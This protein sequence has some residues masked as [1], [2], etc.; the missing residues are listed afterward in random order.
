MTNPLHKKIHQHG[1]LTLLDTMGNDQAIV[2]AASVS[3]GGKKEWTPKSTERLIRYLLRNHHT[4]PF[5]MVE[6]KFH[7]KAPIFIARQWL[8]HRTANVNEISGR[9]SEL[10]S[11]Y[12]TPEDYRMQSKDN[13]QGSGEVSEDS[14]SITGQTTKVCSGAFYDYK[15]LIDGGISKEQARMILP[16]S[17]YTEFIWKCDLHNIFNFIRLRSHHHAQKEIR[18]YADAMFAMVKEKCPLACKAFEDYVLNDGKD[19][20]IKE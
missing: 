8:R 20:R 9:Y 4:S 14:Y 13:K 10:P 19:F 15:C 2:E 5:E 12:Y 3:Y 6:M 16:L 18:D 7:V 17:T 11:E 1:F